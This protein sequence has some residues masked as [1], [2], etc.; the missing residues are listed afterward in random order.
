MLKRSKA[1]FGGP[2]IKGKILG[3]FG[4]GAIGVMVANAAVALGMIMSAMTRTSP[5]RQATSLDKS[6]KITADLD[7]LLPSHLYI[8]SRFP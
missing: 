4:L 2:E 7:D 1:N 6:V 8:L 5:I 3:V